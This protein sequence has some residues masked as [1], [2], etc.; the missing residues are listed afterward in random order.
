STLITSAPR[1]ASNCPDHGPAR[2]RASSRTRTPASGLDVTSERREPG[3]RT[4]ED[5]AVDIMRALV[6]VH[7]LEICGMAGDGEVGPNG[8]AAMHVARDAGDGECL[9]AIVAL[10]ERDEVGLEDALFHAAADAERGLKAKA[11][12]GHHVGELELDELAPG[13]RSAELLAIERVGTR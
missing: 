12:L 1:S 10:G 5:Q 2:M 4:A 7:R 8:I 13:E 3:D 6:G 11:D 9:A